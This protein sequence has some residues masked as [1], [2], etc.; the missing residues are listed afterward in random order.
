MDEEAVVA[1]VDEELVVADETVDGTVEADGTVGAG[2]EEADTLLVMSGTDG[3]GCGAETVIAT[4]A[5]FLGLSS[6]PLSSFI[7]AAVS[8]SSVPFE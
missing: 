2:V 8:F 6:W 4:V 7:A 3:R 1:D 5:V